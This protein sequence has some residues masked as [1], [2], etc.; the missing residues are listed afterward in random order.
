MTRTSHRG[1]SRI[2]PS[3]A[4]DNAAYIIDN[5]FGAGTVVAGII[6]GYAPFSTAGA[7][8]YSTANGNGYGDSLDDFPSTWDT[9]H[10][11]FAAVA[12][13]PATTAADNYPSLDGHTTFD[14]GRGHCARIVNAVSG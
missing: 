10:G 2:L 12:T 1:S 9:R 11:M 5:T 13:I 8:N 7:R 4:N 3:A 6:P 14:A